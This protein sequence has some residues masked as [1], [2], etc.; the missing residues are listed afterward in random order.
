MLLNW[1]S[2]AYVNFTF[3]NAHTSHD[4]ARRKRER[5]NIKNYAECIIHVVVFVVVV[6]S[7]RNDILFDFICK[8]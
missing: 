3:I 1:K 7:Y 5:I 4:K 2:F 6:V 8:I